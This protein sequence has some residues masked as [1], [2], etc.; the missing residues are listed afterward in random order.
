MIT[1]PCPNCG[2]ELALLEQYQRY[3]CYACARYAPEG[4]GDRGAKI[5]PTCR[6]I[7]SYVPQYDRH[8]CFRC[9]AYPADDAVLLSIDTSAPGPSAAQAT[10]SE[11]AVVLME[12]AKPEELAVT[13]VDVPREP[14]PQ[15]E[16]LEAEEIPTEDQVPPA[17]PPLVREEILQARKPTLMDWCKAYDLDPTGTKEQLRERL[18]SYLDTLE[19]EAEPRD[20]PAEAH[21]VEETSPTE[22]A[23]P[24]DAQP[25]VGSET[26]EPVEET[27]EVGRTEEPTETEP[28]TTSGRAVAP[29]IV[30][31]RPQQES[32]VETVAAPFAQA[33]PMP[34]ASI[35]QTVDVEPSRGLHACP[36]CGRGLMYIA[37]YRRWYCYHCR[38]YAPAGK[39]KFAC[40]NCGAALRW[41]P[42]YERWWCDA[43]RRYA[44]ADLPKPEIAAA[45][46]SAAVA[47]PLAQ[48]ATFP[49]TTLVHRHRSPGSGIGLVG[50]GV[51]LF[52]LYEV[53]VDLPGIL[54]FRTGFVVSPD[55]AFGLRFFA[56][57]FV[58]VGAIMGLSAVRDRR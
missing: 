18:L 52:V 20:I 57:V 49:T 36:T 25:P 3:Y 46:A 32:V 16:E 22:S 13:T 19:A 28:A 8:Y 37:L 11:P 27:T 43:C 4:Y 48:V 54:S 45:T 58:A 12:P 29:A 26:T 33:G 56:F 31:T 5:C 53:L 50:F 34:Q 23:A 30:E 44:P 39:S 47:R 6:G 51:V 38:A 40:P 35:V 17:K 2:S 42:Q 21:A 41:I 15:P 55:L 9:S 1:L 24:V 10:T 7:L 14:S